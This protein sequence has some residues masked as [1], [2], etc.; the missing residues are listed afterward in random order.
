MV[1]KFSKKLE[2][3]PQNSR[4]KEGDIQHVQH[5]GATVHNLVATVHNL[6]ATATWRP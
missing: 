1:H 5:R 2:A 4:H 6:V 3:T